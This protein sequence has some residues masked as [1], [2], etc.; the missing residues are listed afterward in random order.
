MTKPTQKFR[1]LIIAL[2]SCQASKFAT[3]FKSKT[4]KEKSFRYPLKKN[5]KF[6]IRIKFQEKV[7]L[8]KKTL[9]SRGRNGNTQGCIRLCNSAQYLHNS[10]VISGKRFKFSSFYTFYQNKKLIFRFL[11]FI[12]TTLLKIYFQT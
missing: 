2:E 9:I 10:T 1:F 5:L 4:R 8:S 11:F 12:I 7:N 3:K 6:Y